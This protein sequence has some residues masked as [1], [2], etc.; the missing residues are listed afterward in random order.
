MPD[1]L[2]ELFSE[3]IPARMQ[4]RAAEDLRRLVTDALV[5]AGLTYASAGAFATPRRLVLSVEGLPAMSPDQREERKGPRVDAPEKAIEGFLRATGLGRDAL[6]IRD[7]KKGQV[8]FAVIARPGRTAAEILAEILPGVI[9]NFPWPKSMRWGSRNLRWV[10][11]L[12]RILCILSDE[13]GSEIVPFDVDGLASADMSEGHRFMAPGS[14]RVSSWADYE[15]QLAQRF[16]LLDAQERAQKIRHDAEQLAFAQGLELVGDP[17]LLQEVAGLVE[18]PVVLMGEIDT[19]FLGL[20]AEVLQTSMR[21]HQKFFSVRNPASGGIEKWITV[22]NRET[23]D[24]GAAIVAGNARVLAARL[25]DAKFFWENDL[26]VAEAGLQAWLDKLD[27]VTF[28]AKLGSVGQQVARIVRLSREIAPMIGADPEQAEQAARLAKVDLVSEM[29]YEFPDLQGVMGRYYARAAGC[30]DTV[31]QAVAQHY[32]PLGPADLVPSEPVAVSVA[33]AEKLDRLLGFW[34]IDE[35]PTGSKD[36]F[37]LRRAAIGV[38]RLLL[39]N[40]LRLSLPKLIALADGLVLE[41]G[42]EPSDTQVASITADLLD[43]FNDRLKVHLRA[44]GVRHDVIDACYQLGDQDDLVLLVNRVRALQTVLETEDGANLV[45]GYKRANNILATEEKR[46]GVEY[47][48]DP[49]PGLAENDVERD[50]FKALDMARGRIAPA[51]AAEDFTAA[52]AAMADLRAPIDRF[53]D[54]VTVN[55]EMAIVRRNR[56]CLLNRIRVVMNSV[57]IFSALDG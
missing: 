33:L 3:E 19:A 14:F 54:E 47:S 55:A 17:G 18:W 28:H 43:F 2:F 45:A 42:V 39:E 12:S 16:V 32:A 6:E 41:Q 23:S 24:Q 1:L 8:Y 26:R 56:L 13:Q 38:I 29:V 27:A 57:A 22:A 40:G 25:S 48:L 35:K 21:A 49:E 31:A 52:M 20:P 50:L 30:S 44:E 53:F 46:D 15:S 11:P 51:L 37:A 7:D 5:E 36:P 9:R 4:G 34:I 10:R